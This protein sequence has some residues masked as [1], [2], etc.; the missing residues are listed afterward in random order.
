[1]YILLLLSF[2]HLLLNVPKSTFNIV[3]FPFFQTGPSS[4]TFPFCSVFSVC[5]RQHFFPST[6]SILPHTGCE[7]AVPTE[8]HWCGGQ[9]YVSALHQ[10]CYCVPLWDWYFRQ[11]AS[12][13]DRTGAQTHVQGKLIGYEGCHESNQKK[14]VTSLS[15]GMGINKN[16]AIQV[17]LSIS[18]LN[19]IPFNFNSHY[20]PTGLFE[21][22]HHP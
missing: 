11:E 7:S 3:S 8:Q 9:C 19:S 18:L 20:F 16:L 4:Y 2:P 14:L 6:L 13:Q 22:Q 12:A 17:P 10:P 21:S 15:L 1:M 5:V